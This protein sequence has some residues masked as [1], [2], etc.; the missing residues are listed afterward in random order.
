MHANTCYDLLDTFDMKSYNNEY[1][2]NWKGPP[3]A[4]KVVTSEAWVVWL[5]LAVAR[6]AACSG[7]CLMIASMSGCRYAFTLCRLL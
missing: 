4:G 1:H 3:P 2:I 6:G 7:F 5:V